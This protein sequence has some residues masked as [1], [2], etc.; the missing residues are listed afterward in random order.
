ML[1]AIITEF[2]RSCSVVPCIPP[3][4]ISTASPGAQ[5]HFTIHPNLQQRAKPYLSGVCRFSNPVNILRCVQL[6]YLLISEVGMGDTCQSM[7]CVTTWIRADIES[8]TWSGQATHSTGSQK[9]EPCQWSECR[10]QRLHHG[11]TVPKAPLYWTKLPSAPSSGLL[12]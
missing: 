7:V 8:K 4:W 10:G 5:I 6:G 1:D 11:G 12:V 9:L 2:Y 3:P